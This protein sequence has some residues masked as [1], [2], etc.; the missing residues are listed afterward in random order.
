MKKDNEL[1][2]IIVYLV[3]WSVMIASILSLV[4]CG[5]PYE[6]RRYVCDNGYST[7]WI[8]YGSYL[9]MDEGMISFDRSKYVVPEGTTCYQEQK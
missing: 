4:G 7:E 8:P 1:G 5:K 6:A 2:V 3:I 9:N